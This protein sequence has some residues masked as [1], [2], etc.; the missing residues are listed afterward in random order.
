MGEAG[1]RGGVAEGDDGGGFVD[2]GVGEEGVGCELGVLAEVHKAAH[3]RSP[4][5]QGEYVPIR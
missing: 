2:E 1:G 3:Q 4:P 5:T